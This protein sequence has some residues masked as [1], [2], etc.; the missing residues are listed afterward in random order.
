[1][2]QLERGLLLNA[3]KRKKEEGDEKYS[4]MCIHTIWAMTLVFGVTA[5]FIVGGVLQYEFGTGKI[6]KE[7]HLV[8]IPGVRCDHF[9]DGKCPDGWVCTNY[10]CHAPWS[11]NCSSIPKTPTGY[12][13]KYDHTLCA[14]VTGYWRLE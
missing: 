13:Y 5:A 4:R 2:E 14:T 12:R 8:E 6:I 3:E 1:M 10:L 9:G 7:G 11:Q